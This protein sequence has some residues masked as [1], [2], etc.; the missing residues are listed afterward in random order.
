MVVILYHKN[1]HGLMV[2]MHFATVSPRE[3]NQ[4]NKVYHLMNFP[5]TIY[6]SDKQLSGL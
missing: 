4:V 6:S 1:L 2:S 5:W 3:P